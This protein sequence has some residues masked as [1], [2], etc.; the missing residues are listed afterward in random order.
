LL[1]RVKKSKQTTD[2]TAYN[3]ME[4]TYNLSGALVEQ[5]YPSG[6]IVK[7]ILDNNGDLSIVQ[8]KKNSDYGFWNYAEHFTYTAAGAVSSMQLGNGRWESA[9]FNSRMQPTQ[10][11]LGVTQNA[12]NL[13]DLDFSYG[14]TANNG[15]V[16]SQTI[17]VPTVGVN[18]GF[19][20]VQNYAYD[21]LNRI[22]DAT[23]NLTPIGGSSVQTWK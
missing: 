5:K 4:Y 21:S 18:T 17:T 20:A 12:T 7:N 14:T 2:G 3:E 23:E 8:S 13:L 11:A 1:G 6:R 22:K 19:T 16:Q 15:N 10:I 9:T